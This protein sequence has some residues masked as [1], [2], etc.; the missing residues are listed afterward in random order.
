VPHNFSHHFVQG[1]AVR[2]TLGMPK[3]ALMQVVYN[4]RRFL[5]KVIPAALGQTENAID[6]Q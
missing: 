2:Y 4:F 5:P 1:T 3:V 6:E